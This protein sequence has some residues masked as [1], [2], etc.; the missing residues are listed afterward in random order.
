MS[1]IQIVAILVI[2]ASVV[3]LSAFLRAVWAEAQRI[4]AE[5]EPVDHEHSDSVKTKVK[6]ILVEGNMH[7][8]CPL[9]LAPG[10]FG[11]DKRYLTGYNPEE[12]AE[13]FATHP[14]LQALPA[15]RKV[16]VANILLTGWPLCYVPPGDPRIGQPVG[17]DC[18]NCGE[19]R[20]A[21]VPL[22]VLRDEVFD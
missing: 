13:T 12:V 10:T 22:G 9:C 8:N 5:P 4:L 18:P 6:R 7:P 21:A 2:F 17:P 14:A 19:P 1:L 15:T 11:A 3:S 16:Q 20:P